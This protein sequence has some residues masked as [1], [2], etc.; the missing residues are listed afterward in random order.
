MS[1]TIQI[2]LLSINRKKIPFRQWNKKSLELV[3]GAITFVAYS[4]EPPMTV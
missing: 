3:K 1:T 2:K 4:F